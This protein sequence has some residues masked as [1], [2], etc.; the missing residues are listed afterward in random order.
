M[1]TT[2]QTYPIEFR[3]GLITNMSPLQQGI[4]MPGSARTLRNFEPSVEGGYR[5]IEGFD[6]YDSNIIPPYGDPVVRGASQTGTS[7]NIGNI[8]QEPEP[9]DTFKLVHATAEVN[10]TATASV[11]GATTTTT[12]VAVDGNSGT[13]VVGMTVTSD[14]MVGSVTVA[15]VTDQ[16]NIVLSAA[17]SLPDNEVLT[18]GPPDAVTTTHILDSISGTIAAGMDVS[19]TGVPSGVTVSAFSGSTVTLSE[20]V[21]LAD[22]IALTFSEVYTIAA[23]GVN[24]NDTN[25]TADLTLSASLLASPSNGDSLEFL[26]TNSN[27]LA[28]GCG[29]FTD[30]V[31]VAKNES[32]YRTG[33]TGY[34][35]INV[36]SY[37]TVLVNGASQTGTS[38][39]IDGLT[40]TP[41]GGDVFK[42]AGVDLIYT[43]TSTPTVTSGGTTLTITPALDSSPADNAAITFLSTSRESAGKTRFSKYNYDGTDKVAIVDGTNP[44]AL[45]DK[46]TFTALN[47]APSDVLGA[48]FVVNFKNHL[49][50]GKDNL[51]TFTA[52]YTDNDFISANGS[53]VISVGADITGLVVFRQQ[54]IIFTN[55]SIF[56]LTGNTIADFALQS[57]TLDIGCPNTDTIQ[58]VGGDIMFLGPD[59]LRLLSATDRIGDFGL[60]VVS[61]GIQKEVTDFIAANTSFASVVIREK[62]QYRILGYNTNISATS[63]QGIL[64][65]QFAGQGGDGMSWSDLRGI[66]AYVADSKLNENTE[67]IVFAHDDGYLYQME[68]GSSFDGGNISSSFSTPYLPINDP[69]VRKTFYKMFLYTDPQGSVTFNSSLKLDFDQ[70]DSIQPPQISINNS[71]GSV[72]FY[73]AGTFGTATFGTKL[74]SVFETQII[75]SGFVVSLQFTSDSTDPPYSLDAI[76]LEYGTNTRR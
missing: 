18:F 42:I 14:S 30:I 45:Y 47:D 21:T 64:G 59:G 1:P 6:K 31:I 58:E 53:G 41:Q 12:A 74:L 57:V 67:T 7:L 75:G 3:G 54:L 61:K 52:P 4:N 32:L 11:N 51:L 36:P 56:Q 8:R 35:L 60:A 33:G 62:S 9:G 76:T 50:F 65:T 55:S 37:G 19:G 24:F 17:Q 26:T 43:I 44:P 13:I 39:I 16:N 66:R 73:G 38:L 5:R 15:T 20:A 71:T 25:N 40:S 29:V 46:S 48:D 22:N 27:Y 23:G 68:Q 70:K 10:N 63:A 34:T 69:R 28:K 2:R 49:F 72:A